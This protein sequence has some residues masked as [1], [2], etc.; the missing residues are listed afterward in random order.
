MGP[1]RSI[2]VNEARRKIVIIMRRMEYTG[3]ITVPKIQS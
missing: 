1:V 2:D 3:E